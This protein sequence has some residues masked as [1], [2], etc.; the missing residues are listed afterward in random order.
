MALRSQGVGYRG[1]QGRA[2]ADGKDGAAGR[3]GANGTNGTN[4]KDGLAGPPGLGTVTPSTPVR[5]LGTAFQPHATKAVFVSYSVKTQVTNPALAGAS[6]AT[7]TLLSDV[8]NPPTTERARDEATSSVGLAVSIAL[9]TSNTA[10]LSYIVP[11]G[12]FVR[13]VSTITGT[14][15]TSLVSQTEEVLG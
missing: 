5:V 10:P 8:N 3:D 7:V 4:G 14:G 6:V 12:H 1:A 15:S 11:P 2:G 13:L 9:T